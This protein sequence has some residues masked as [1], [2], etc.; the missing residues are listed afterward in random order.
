M[1]NVDCSEAVGYTA[2]EGKENSFGQG[3]SKAGGWVFA[4]QFDAG[5]E[6]WF[7]SVSSIF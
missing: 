3:F 4:I 7:W 1:V 2:V 6:I 5:V